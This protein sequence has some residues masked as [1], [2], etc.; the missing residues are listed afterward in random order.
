MSLYKIFFYNV[1]KI[2]PL[3]AV[4]RISNELIFIVLPQCLNVSLKVIRDH[5]SMQFKLLSCISGVDFLGNN[6]RF[7][8]VYDFLSLTF[9]QRLRLKTFLNE[10]TPIASITSLYINANWW[11]RET[12]DMYGIFF[13]KHPDLRRILSDY[14]F[15]GFPMRKDFPLYG[16]IELRYDENVKRIVAEPVELAQ[17]FR[18]FDFETPW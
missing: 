14:G 4:Q 1:S 5:I 6:Y 8:V 15:E 16:Y 12:W 13:E 9:N 17:E 18:Y 7:S 2:I 11:E 10:V 3:V